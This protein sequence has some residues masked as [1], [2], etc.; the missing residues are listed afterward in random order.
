MKFTIPG[1]RSKVHENTSRPHKP[2]PLSQA[3][4]TCRDTIEG[5]DKNQNPSKATLSGFKRNVADSQDQFPKWVGTIPF[6]PYFTYSDVVRG[7]EGS[8]IHANFACETRASG[9]GKATQ[10]LDQGQ[11]LEIMN[12]EYQVNETPDSSVSAVRDRTNLSYR[13]A[14]NSYGERNKSINDPIR[15]KTSSQL[16]LNV[17]RNH[18]RIPHAQT[19]KG[20]RQRNH[21]D[22]SLRIEEVPP[23]YRDTIRLLVK[24]GGLAEQVSSKVFETHII[25]ED[26]SPNADITL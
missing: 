21:D 23:L 19:C 24:E 14:V 18:D 3:P 17:G 20:V 25:F 8:N 13:A 12:S 26:G 4:M 22:T 5:I 9:S 1:R 16:T 15:A 10:D 6:R 7:G 2:N 11:G